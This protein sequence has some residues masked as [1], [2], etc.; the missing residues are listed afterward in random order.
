MEL[1]VCGIA[2]SILTIALSVFIFL[3]MDKRSK[4]VDLEKRINNLKI[5]YEF[6]S[7]GNKILQS[8]NRDLKNLIDDGGRQRLILKKQIESLTIRLEENKK[9]NEAFFKMINDMKNS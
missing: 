4:I 1:I 3:F 9:K 6:L 7:T 2:I 5:T 8:T